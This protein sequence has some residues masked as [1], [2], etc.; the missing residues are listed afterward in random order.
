[1]ATVKIGIVGLGRMGAAIVYRL[2]S[3]GHEVVGF[4]LD[5]GAR[6]TVVGYGAQV[7]DTLVGMISQV[8]IIWLMVPAGAITHATFSQILESAQA[9]TIIIDGGNSY[10]EDSMK[11]AH[12]AQEKQMFFL[13]CGTSGGVRGRESGFCLM[14]GGDKGAY[15]KVYPLLQAIAAPAGT[16]LVGPS[17]AGHYVKMVHN[18]IEYALLQSYAEGF[19][20]IREGSFKDQSLNLEELSRLWSVSSV[21]R[22]FILELTHDIFKED[23]SLE[24]VS[25]EVAESGMGLWTVQEADKHAIP[26]PMIDEALKIRA[27]SRETGGNYATKVVA[28]LRNKFGGHAFTKIKKN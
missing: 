7:S 27:W 16:S 25:G 8:S 24:D 20:V 18:G 22:S 6:Q 17:G 5:L 21:I 15:E 23:Y 19:Q 2:V 11:H 1:M 12:M 9:G 10:Y 13:D 28:L 4:D 3:A 26:V 14:V